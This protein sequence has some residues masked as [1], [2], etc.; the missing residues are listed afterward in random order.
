MQLKAERA[1]LSRS[2]DER[3]KNLAER[4]RNLEEEKSNSVRALAEAEASRKAEIAAV[5]EA[6]VQKEKA[7]TA[8]RAKNAFL[9]N[10]SHELRTP[11]HAVLGFSQLM[12]RRKGRDEEDLEHLAIIG[13]SGEHLLGIIEDVLSL[14]RIEA[15]V[16]NLSPIPFE[17]LRMLDGLGSMLRVRAEAKGLDLVL[18]FD[19]SLPAIVVGDAGKLRQILLNLLSNAVK[20]TANGRVIFRARWSGGRAFFEVEDA[21][22]GMTTAEM[23]TL[24]QAF[25]QT[26]T[27]RKSAEGTGLGLAISRSFA[28]Q[29]GG[30]ITVVSEQG[31]GTIFRVV[32]PLPEADEA[33]VASVR[34]DRRPV[35]GLAKGETARRILVVDDVFENRLL[36]SRLLSSLGFQ[37]TEAID[38]LEAVEQWKAGRPE[39]IFMDVR[40]PVMDGLTATKR[41]REAEEG[42]DGVEPGTRV[43]IVALSASALPTEQEDI[44]KAG[45]DAFLAKP[46]REGAIFERLTTLLGVQFERE[47]FPAPKST[48]PS[49]PPTANGTGSSGSQA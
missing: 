41:I 47:E 14:C 44:L 17:L 46:I 11:L 43:K 31:K 13:R 38:G 37:V 2:M 25:V 6:D 49:A 4:T 28:R 16:I 23:T 8:T 32:L 15:G 10:M 3:A 45:C 19:G 20:F 30:E 5:L 39:L 9:T 12:A 21:G 29:M 7:E 36:L 33:A 27:G 42:P 48:S 35:I 34:G 1:E 40:M 24:F 22:P 18:E 26:E